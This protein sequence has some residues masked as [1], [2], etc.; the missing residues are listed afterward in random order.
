[1]TPLIYLRDTALYTLPLGLK[2][3]LDQQGAGGGGEGR[4][5]IIMA[6]TVLTVL[7]MLILFAIFQRFFVE[8]IATQGGGKG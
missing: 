1:M 6:G 8:G 7:P 5:E 4:W 2:T 3:I